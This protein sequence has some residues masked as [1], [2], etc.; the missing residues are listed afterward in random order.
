VKRSRH[1]SRLTAA[2]LPRLDE[3]LAENSARSQGG[4]YDGGPGH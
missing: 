1:K 2:T 3:I 4:A